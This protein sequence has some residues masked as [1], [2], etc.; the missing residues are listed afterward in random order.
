MIIEVNSNFVEVL[1]IPTK[2]TGLKYKPQLRNGNDEDWAYFTKHASKE[3][4]DRNFNIV[5]DICKNYMTHGII[6]IGVSRNQEGSFTYA[7]LQNKPDDLKYLGID[8]EDKS[9]LNNV[10]KNIFT[11]KENSFNQSEV[12][13][14][15]DKIGMDKISILFIDGWHSVNACINDWLYSDLLSDNG[16]V[17]FHDTNSHPGPRVFIECIDRNQYKV[18]RY[19]IDEDDYGIGIA[20]KI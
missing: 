1:E 8:I 14:Y 17:I 19:F 18:E 15:L 4:S 11:I 20:Y 6:E 3:V 9:Y 12:R 10:E 7:M 2:I 16:I 13:S 5:R